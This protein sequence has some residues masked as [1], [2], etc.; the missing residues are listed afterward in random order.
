MSHESRRVL[1]GSMLM[2]GMLL[3]LPRLAA[4]QSW[5][6]N[7][8]PPCD[9]DST[10]SPCYKPK[11][12]DPRCEPED[13]DKC[14]KSPCYV[15]SGDYAFS[16]GDLVL[17]TVAAPL[18]ATR[19]YES[20]L[21]IDGPLGFGWTSS[22]TARLTYAAYLLSPP[23]SVVT[24][25]V[26]TMPNGGR[27]VFRQG[28]AGAFVPPPGRRDEL[29][30]LP[31]GRFVLK[32]QKGGPE[33]TF[34]GDGS[35]TSMSDRY[36]NTIA[37][38]RDSFGRV[39]RM[40]DLGGSERF[41]EVFWGND[42]RIAA[43]HD[44]AGR[45]VAYR[46]SGVGALVEVDD[47]L[48]RTWGYAYQEGRYGPILSEVR[49]PWGRIVTSIVYDSLDR[50]QSYTDQ[51]VVWT[52]T[53][54]YGG[55]PT[56]T[57]KQASSGAG[58]LFKFGAAGLVER[59]ESIP[60]G[61]VTTTLYDAD[62]AITQTVDA[63]GLATRYQ[64]D[65]LG[66][67]ASITRNEGG[68]SAVRFEYSYDA[69]HPDQVLGIRA[70]DPVSGLTNTAWP[71]AQFEYWGAGSAAP[72]AL[73][74]TLRVRSDGVNADSMLS[75]EYDERGLVVRTLDATGD[76]T[77]YE[78][79]AAGD[80]TRVLF[81]PN[82][83][84]G[85][86]P[87]VEYEVDGLGRVV[88]RRDPDG[89][90]TAGS[91]DPA[92]RQLMVGLMRGGVTLEAETWTYDVPSP[93]GLLS[94]LVEDQNGVT[95]EESRDVW[96]RI[97]ARKDG[98]GGVTRYSY[99]GPHLI[100]VRDPN[101]NSTTYAYDADGRPVSRTGALGQVEHYGYSPA[102]N[103][104]SIVDAQGRTT[105]MSYDGFGRVAWTSMGQ[106]EL[107]YFYT[108]PFVTRIEHE[109][110]A[111]AVQAYTYQLDSRY[112]LVHE[113]QGSRGEISYSYDLDG[114]VASEQIADGPSTTYGYYPDG[115]LRGLTWSPLGGE[116]LFEYTLVGDTS[117][118]VF[119]GG[120][121]RA[122][123]YDGRGRLTAVETLDGSQGLL[124]RYAYGYDGEGW[125]PLASAHG[126]LRTAVTVDMPTLGLSQQ[127]T[128]YRY[129]ASYRLVRAEYG[130]SGAF[131]GRNDE[132][133]YDA[134]GN[135]TAAWVGN[136]QN[137]YQYQLNAAGNNSAR[138]LHVGADALSYNVDGSVATWLRPGG[139]TTFDYS[140]FADPVRMDS[141]SVTV[142]VERDRDGVRTDGGLTRGLVPLWKGATQEGV[143][144]DPQSGSV[145][146]ILRSGGEVVLAVVDGAMNVTMTVDVSGQVGSA[147]LFDAWGEVLAGVE[148]PEAGFVG[149]AAAADNV[150]L[151]GYRFFYPRYGRF[152]SADPLGRIN[153][154]Q[155]PE[156]E[157][158]YAMN[159]P[160]MYDDSV[161][162]APRCTA[163]S[164]PP[165]LVLDQA[166]VWDS[167]WIP[168]S[169]SQVDITANP[170]QLAHEP[171]QTHIPPPR[172]GPGVPPRN[173]PAMVAPPAGSGDVMTAPNFS[174]KVCVWLRRHVH[175][176]FWKTQT[177]VF[178]SCEDDC[179]RKSWGFDDVIE[180]PAGMTS[181]E[182][183][184]RRS[185]IG[186]MIFGLFHECGKPN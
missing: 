120:T 180:S 108:G 15:G 186:L 137:L 173:R 17:P 31:D 64:H 184:E 129:D 183:V 69:Q 39:E 135:R 60:S 37:I 154:T 104:S 107:R 164:T 96:G 114:R 52:Y 168:Y 8:I 99:S 44:S 141:P 133:T 74:R 140:T 127:A 132:W 19:S 179:P 146:A 149:Q 30:R 153:K 166:K 151:L 97:V 10:G 35:L 2:A 163:T 147:V 111:G 88:A 117:A 51:G 43:L 7:P 82:N 21:A 92:G 6:N 119:P 16:V 170:R 75:Y 126:G 85:Q 98:Q 112:R 101:G 109:D 26:L 78:Y 57:R 157:Y 13:C 102:G 162:L 113:T 118:V 71:A 134:I 55:D 81:P 175:R 56:V 167:L 28:E 174:F 103:V 46:Y 63:S 62:G 158:A 94:T 128:R 5:C 58:F 47:L 84:S 49:D 1:A 95:L 40:S 12:K 77:D 4:G 89:L 50:V 32:V 177:W 87:I 159:S 178:V 142:N 144:R 176:Y 80:L 93:D 9:P 83:D 171:G 148:A 100:E 106:E 36:G 67:V 29:L 169:S 121:K 14:K 65:S 20:A 130:A 45:G 131:Q 185:S 73:R 91:F 124:A 125:I 33:V 181:T 27:Y 38:D 86:R 70:V 59:S 143:L 156:E 115:S 54:G 152:L 18:A 123:S 160:V 72:G 161:G 150:R 182:W 122:Y 24:Q 42:G 66:R 53:Y 165:M 34:A 76:A 22:L 25:A 105:L 3:G 110:D 11:P 79:N 155:M 172:Y 68:T 48:G 136:A 90:T 23:S 41:I 138:L 139:T 116:I 145:L 61:A